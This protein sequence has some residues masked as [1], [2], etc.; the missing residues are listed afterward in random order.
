MPDEYVG[1]MG[2]EGALALK[3]FA[4]GGGT[5]IAFGGAVDFAIEQLGLPVRDV[6]SSA[7]S[8]DFSIPGSLIRA[9]ADVSDP[10]AWGMD[11]EVVVNFV[12]GAAFD[13]LG[14]EGCVDDLLNQRNC[15]EVLRGD[16]PLKTFDSE[17]RFETIVSY[18]EKREDQEDESDEDPLLMSGWAK[19]TEFIA[20]KSALVRVPL[21]EGNVVL[22]GFRHFLVRETKL[23][24]PD[25]DDVAMLQRMLLD[26]LAVDVGAIGAVQVFEEGI[27]EDIDDER[28]VPT[29]GWI[30]DADIVV[31]QAAN[32]VPLFGHVV[33][34]QDLVVQA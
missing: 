14:Q 28:V 34:G 33:F 16:R 25:G 7:S 31:G 4:E 20:G 21:G 18:A 12:N 13:V 10:L 5:V 30:V 19:G 26:Q 9:N 6:V 29:D 2:L 15:H 23:V 1:G 24:V 32:R 27:V 8:K 22:F 17:P 3:N 11:G